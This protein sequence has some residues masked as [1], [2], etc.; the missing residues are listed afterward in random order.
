MTDPAP[1][2][3]PADPAPEPEL[4]ADPTPSPW[5]P[6]PA[7]APWT[8]SAP[9]P[10]RPP[11]AAASTPPGP[12]PTTPSGYDPATI[13]SAP[14]PTNLPPTGT[15]PTSHAPPTA[16][17]TGYAPPTAAPTG[18]A[19]PTAAPTGYAPTGYVVPGAY[20][21]GYAPPPG[22]PT[23]DPPLPGYPTDPSAAGY[24][25]PAWAGTPAPVRGRTNT[26]LVAVVVVLAVLLCGGAGVAVAGLLN[27]R[28]STGPAAAPTLPPNGG[29]GGPVLPAPSEPDP[30]VRTG[31]QVVYQVS[32][33][34]PAEV[35]YLEY[36]NMPRQLGT[37]TL[38]WRVEFT[39]PDPGVVTVLAIRSEAD[40]GKITCTIL[41][42]GE[43]VTTN[44]AT[45]P[46]ATTTCAA[47]TLN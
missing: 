18:Y 42:D 9:A 19:P 40:P 30:T 31:R 44:S 36:P 12:D 23:G 35:S 43:A 33:D 8:P 45:G 22:Y 25:P 10:W 7:P 1:P 17:P 34:G 32:G 37:T 29:A 16:S 3:P 39:M 47:L 46:H 11:A 21:T 26:G 20:S 28:G 4:T 38:P 27:W 6:P 14:T 13:W 5:A 2:Q 41:V 15:S 24:P